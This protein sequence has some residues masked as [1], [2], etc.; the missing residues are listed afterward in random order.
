MYRTVRKCMALFLSALLIGGVLLSAPWSALADDSGGWL[1]IA[2]VTATSSI[3]SALTPGNLIDGRED[4]F[5]SSEIRHE[6][7]PA[8]GE[9]A[10]LSLNGTASVSKIALTPR[11]EISSAFPRGFKL[12]YSPDKKRWLD[13]PGQ[14][15]T[16]YTPAEGETVFSFSPVEA[17]KIRIVATQYGKDDA[18]YYLMQLG[19]VRVYGVIIAPP[20]AAIW[21]ESPITEPY[22]YVAEGSFSG[23][24]QPASP[25]PLVAYRWENPTADDALEIFLRRPVSVWSDAPEQF[26]G[27]ETLT[28]ENAAVEVK[29]AGCI[30]MDFG[31]EFA[32]WLE[33]DAPDLSGEITLGVSEYNQ[34]AIVNRG[35]QSPAK[36]ATPVK[37]GDTYR[38]E[39][40]SELYEG[41]RFGFITVTGF[42]RPFTITDVRL[43]CQTKPI[44]Y[45]GS[46]DSDNE[47]LNKIWYA[48]AYDVR[49]NLKEDYLAAILVDRGDRH[50]WTGDAYTSQAASLAAFGNYD[51]IL[52]NLRYTAVRPNGIESYELYWVLSLID[53]Y[54]YSGD[55]AGVESLL[56]EVTARLDH[57]YEIYGSNPSLGF[58]G[59]DERLGAGFENPN[60]EENQNSYKL[61]SI[62]AWKDFAA[63]LTEL[64]QI[65]LAKKYAGYADEKTAELTADPEFYKAYG[66]HASADAINA[67]VGEVDRLYHADFD[68]RLNRIS[69]S[70]FN[71]YMLLQAMAKAGKYDDA[72]SAI[73]DLWGGQIEYGGTMFFETFRPGWN[74]I[75]GKNDPVPNNQAGYT[76][77]AHPWSAGVLSWLNEEILGIKAETAGFSSFTVKPHLG[78]QLERVS[79]GT[80]TPYGTIE[81][82][83]DTAAGLHTVTVPEGTVAAVAIPKVE[84]RITA[85]TLNGGAASPTGE[86]EDY[87]Y[88]TGLAAGSYT[89]RAQ[90]DGTTPEYVEGEYL[91]PAEFVGIDAETRGSWNGVYGADGYLLPGYNGDDVRVL[92]EYVRNVRLSKGRRVTLTADSD[93]VRAMP[94][95]P[96]GAGGRALGAY[97][98]DDDTACYQTFTVD[99]D[100]LKE[101]EY[102]VALYFADW[103]CAGRELMVEMFDGQTLNLVAPLQALHDYSG[104][105]YL[106]YRCDRSARFRINHIR[107]KNASLSGIFFGEGAGSGAVRSTEMVDDPD[108]RI[109]YTGAWNHNPLGDAYNGT[110]SYTDTA[111]SSAELRFT[112]SGVAYVASLENNRG[113]AEVYLDGEYRGRFDLYS[114]GAVRQDPVFADNDLE[115]GEHTIRVV[116][117]GEKNPLAAGAYVDVDAF[118]IHKP[119]QNMQESKTDDRDAAVSYAGAWTHDPI[120]GAWQDTFSYSG[121]TGD[122]AAFTF[123]GVGISYI[124]SREANRGIAQI[125]V[126]GEVKGTVDLYSAETL[127]QQEVF[128]LDGLPDG[129]HTIEVAVTGEKNPQSGGTY[130]DVDA[131]AV[132]STLYNVNSLADGMTIQNPERG[133]AALTLPPMPEG[134]TV[135][136][137]ESGR[138]EVLSLD[139]SIHAP[140]EDT[141][142]QLVL[143]VSDGQSSARRTASITVPGTAS[144]E[145]EIQQVIEQIAALSDRYT[146]TLSDRE[147]VSAA[148]S[149]YE[150]LDAAGRERVTN[151]SKLVQ[152]ERDLQILSSGRRGDVDMDGGR[153]VSDVVL[154]RGVIVSE[155]RLPAA[156]FWSADL[157]G[158][159]K[160]TVSDVI[161]LRQMIVQA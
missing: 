144:S 130:V 35:P 120:G 27:L 55:A 80:P 138:P 39:L 152:L 134:F 127:R 26:S 91:Y 52:K 38:L 4:T 40:N 78:R 87:L 24:A 114:A 142:L 76:S 64:G 21:G 48:A 147:A 115:Y 101:Q 84:R 102:T 108:A 6:E 42:D 47:T 154:L 83:F 131:F 7:Y 73:L 133:A 151:L 126:D 19:G 46:F 13:I 136:I 111:G 53:Y 31:A 100:L 159:G 70:P 41:A 96:F 57:A 160:L 128:R 28:T 119:F 54:E 139:G 69:Y 94:S 117:T 49:A 112:G 107:G 116:V 37:Y 72:I 44:N 113:I 51:F 65:G 12:Q 5:W 155:E 1:E 141:T 22:D 50:S 74:E 16:D 137:V 103:E 129:Q 125:R 36:T 145:A 25:D 11:K 161:A 75:I 2:G 56:S 153:T 43:V 109:T 45:E 20:A 104:G 118:E 135:S 123:T 140:Q 124:A 77:L 60:L 105:V 14:S 61:L 92:P 68:D 33:I 79:G 121:Q 82:S 106:V 89:F 95:N 143:Q 67:G 63:V 15:Y 132:R 81:A 30:R 18:G 66:L 32:G 98:S 88:F 90:Y 71:E 10:T 86:D 9:S 148:R 29:G 146:L 17:Q 8:E 157:N 3:S 34:P 93:D 23:K 156:Q 59:W 97:Q 85:I 158:D 62:Q 122:T 150:A 99:I 110:F 149:A 58:F